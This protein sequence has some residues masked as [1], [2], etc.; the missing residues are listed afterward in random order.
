MTVYTDAL[1]EAINKIPNVFCTQ[2]GQVKDSR[3]IEFDVDIN[4]AAVPTLKH[5]CWAMLPNDIAI[6]KFYDVNMQLLCETYPMNIADVDLAKYIG[7]IFETLYADFLSSQATIIDK[8]E[9]D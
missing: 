7:S 3:V 5:L 2:Y 8:L 9:S 1:A 4:D 6:V